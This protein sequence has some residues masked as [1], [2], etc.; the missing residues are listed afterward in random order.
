MPHL[1]FKE[2]AA[3]EW[4]VVANFHFFRSLFIQAAQQQ[5]AAGQPIVNSKLDFDMPFYIFPERCPEKS[6]FVFDS[7]IDY[8]AGNQQLRAGLF[9]YLD[10]GIALCLARPD[11]NRAAGIC[12]QE[13]PACFQPVSKRQGKPVVN[14]ADVVDVVRIGDIKLGSG[15]C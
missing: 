4:F 6:F 7:G 11:R 14:I 5:L 2:E 8:D 15:C 3:A 1:C 12:G 9:G 13:L 10:D